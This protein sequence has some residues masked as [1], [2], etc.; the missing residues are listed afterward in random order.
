MTEFEN[1]IYGI[2][3]EFKKVSY[4]QTKDLTGIIN[5]DGCV[6]NSYFLQKYVSISDVDVMAF[7]EEAYNFASFESDV[8]FTTEDVLSRFNEIV[9]VI[10]YKGHDFVL[11][12]HQYAFLKMNDKYKHIF[13]EVPK[14]LCTY[15]INYNEL[16]CQTL[17]SSRI[18]MS[19]SVNN[20]NKPYSLA[21]YYEVLINHMLVDDD[22][23]V[24]FK[25]D[26]VDHYSLRNIHESNKIG[27]FF[28]ILIKQYNSKDTFLFEMKG[29]KLPS[30]NQSDNTTNIK[31]VDNTSRII[32]QMAMLGRDDILTVNADYVESSFEYDALNHEFK[33]DDSRVFNT[34]PF[35]NDAIENF[36]IDE[37]SDVLVNNI[38]VG[39]YCD[40]KAYVE[41]PKFKMVMNEIKPENNMSIAQYLVGLGN[42]MVAVF[43][44]Y[45]NV[46][47]MATETNPSRILMKD[48]ETNVLLS[49]FNGGD[50]IIKRIAKKGYASL[51]FE[52]DLYVLFEDRT[53]HI[54]E[55]S[56]NLEQL[57]FVY[58]ERFDFYNYVNYDLNIIVIDNTNKMEHP[59]M[60]ELLL[61]Q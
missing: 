52:V 16:S 3:P 60:R 6:A 61:K 33:G 13:M 50:N 23:A 49:R 11:R 8:P 28:E 14:R 56:D 26:S 20:G 10:S 44:M 18:E 40:V 5:E 9:I 30:F 39:H 42:D 7:E 58:D 43:H 12:V 24:R 21:L 38:I 32:R 31:P 46:K 34:V 29:Q 4:I 22:G 37:V 53:F 15:G 54:N 27:S 41:K 57:G 25:K 36:E 1:D 2:K 47:Q 51:H 55:I 35:F 48:T 17:H 45:I 59:K 19:S